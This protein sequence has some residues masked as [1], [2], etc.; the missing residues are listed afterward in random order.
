MG[1]YG[2]APNTYKKNK[3]TC[4]P[5]ESDSFNSLKFNTSRHETSVFSNSQNQQPINTLRTNTTS[6][7]LLSSRLTFCKN[8]LIIWFSSCNDSHQQYLTVLNISFKLIWIATV[9]CKM[10][11]SQNYFQKKVCNIIFKL[12][13]YL[14]V[15]LFHN[16]WSNNAH[17]MHKFSL[18]AMNE[19]MGGWHILYHIKKLKDYPTK[20]QFS[21]DSFPIKQ[22]ADI[23][24]HNFFPPL[25]ISFCCHSHLV[26]FY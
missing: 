15:V 14:G 20:I 9:C 24:K 11:I 25:N 19:L 1:K 6:V 26:W 21:F 4:S 16:T 23:I 10:H 12:V 13:W 3:T 17:F 18:H 2:I 8:L 5:Q 7:F 22:K